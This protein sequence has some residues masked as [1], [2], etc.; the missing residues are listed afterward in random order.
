M[1]K[2]LTVGLAVLVVLLA[3]CGEQA[4][5]QPTDSPTATTTQPDAAEPTFTAEATPTARPEVTPSP[6]AADADVVVVSTTM[7]V[8]PSAD[9]S[10]LGYQLGAVVE[11]QG[12]SWAMLLPFDSDW[13]VLN[14]EGGVTSTGQ[15]TL[16]IPQ[17]VEPGGTAYVLT[18]DVSEGVSPEEFDSVEIDVAYRSVDE[19]DVTFEIANTQVRDDQFYGL[20][21][22]GFVTSDEDR[23]FVE[24]VAV[25]LNEAREVIGFATA[26]VMD[27]AAGQRKSFETTG[28]PNQV[29]AADCA[30]TVISATPNDFDFGF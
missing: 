18:Y 16:A 1:P 26:Q 8:P 5:D 6:V 9:F 12:D 22:T 7:M 27:L 24:V 4:P 28:P 23:D 10:L 13:T 14:A 21:A 20:T 3:A 25:C 17:Y 2:L 15:M 29:T 30:D 11:N 19:P